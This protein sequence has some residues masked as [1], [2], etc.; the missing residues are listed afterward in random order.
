[1]TPWVSILT[2]VYNGWEFLDEC[3][4]SVL[5]QT[6]GGWEWIIGING[7]GETGGVAYD[8]A[9]RLMTYSDRIR[10]VN[11]PT[12]KGKCEAMNQ[13]MDLFHPT[14]EWVAVLDCDD[15]WSSTKLAMQKVALEREA[16]GTGVLGTFCTYFGEWNTNGPVLPHGWIHPASVLQSNPLINSSVLIRKELARWSDRFVGLDD[17]DLWCRLALRG[18]PFY[19]IPERLVAHRIHRASAFNAKGIQDVEGLKQFYRNELNGR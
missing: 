11:L 18:I 14:V 7:H 10:V 6:E 5:E 8:R 15:T 4:A 2:P 12:A 17:Y 3:A 16:R 13:M 19:N 1:M 9:H